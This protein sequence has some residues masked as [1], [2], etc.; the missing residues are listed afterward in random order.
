MGYAP[1]MAFIRQIQRRDRQTPVRNNR[2]FTCCAIQ[3][4][5][6]DYPLKAARARALLGCPALSSSNVGRPAQRRALHRQILDAGRH[7][8]RR[9]QLEQSAS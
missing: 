4:V 3:P 5:E 2:D 7:P 8:D 6:Q 1:P 9:I